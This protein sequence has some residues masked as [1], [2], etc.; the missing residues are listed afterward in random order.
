MEDWS[1]KVKW[2]PYSKTTGRQQ[3]DM[4]E[5]IQVPKSMVPLGSVPA[6]LR[7]MCKISR[8]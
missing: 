8:R 5:G 4:C 1:E 6:D 3:R 7:S 2:F